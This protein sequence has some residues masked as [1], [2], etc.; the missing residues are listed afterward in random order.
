MRRV[1][2]GIQR[3]TAWQYALYAV[4]NFFRKVGSS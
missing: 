3:G 1:N 2:R 4:L